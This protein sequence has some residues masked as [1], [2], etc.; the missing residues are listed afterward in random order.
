MSSAL[1][2]DKPTGSWIAFRLVLFLTAASLGFYIPYQYATG[3]HA[4][5]G[6][7]AFLFPLSSILVVAGL[8]LGWKPEVVFRIPFA[9]RAALVLLAAGWIATGLL[10]IPSLTEMTLESPLGGLFATFHM[11]AQHVVLSA[12][13]GA[14]ALSPRATYAW[15][16]VAVPASEKRLVEGTP[17]T[18]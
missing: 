7:Y 14:L 5:A 9:A 15:F 18:A 17:S 16:G 13:V 3:L 1:G 6:P 4:I 2:S 8:V 11:V 12:S 10:C